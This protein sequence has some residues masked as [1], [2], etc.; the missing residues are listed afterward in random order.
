MKTITLW[1]PEQKIVD[2]IQLIQN[3][4][5]LVIKVSILIQPN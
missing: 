4:E 2:S 1:Y 5:Q 3:T